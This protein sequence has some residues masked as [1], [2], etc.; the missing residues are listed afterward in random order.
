MAL[1][2]AAC[3]DDDDAFSQADVDAAVAASEPQ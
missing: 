1:S 3:G 2:L